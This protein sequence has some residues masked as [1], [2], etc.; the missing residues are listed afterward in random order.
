MELLVCGRPIVRDATRPVAVHRWSAL[1]PVMAGD[2]PCLIFEIAV[3]D[4]IAEC[5]ALDERAQPVE[6]THIVKVEF[7]DRE[8]ELRG[9]HDQ[10][11]L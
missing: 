10:P 3:C 6:V 8:A 9:C 11:L 4:C 7:H 5:V 1:E 2:D